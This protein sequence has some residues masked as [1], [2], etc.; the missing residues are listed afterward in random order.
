MLGQYIDPAPFRVIG[1]DPGTD[2]LGVSVLDANLSTN[3]ISLKSSQT[4][5]GSIMCKEYPWIIQTHGEKVARLKSH[6]D[7]LYNLFCQ[8]RP[9]EVVSEAPYMGRFPAAYAAL[10][11][12]L[13]AIRAALM[14][15]D[16]HMPL[17]TVDPATVKHTVGV[18]GKSGDKELMHKAITNLTTISNPGHI[19]LQMLD[20][21]SID[22]I[23]VA[24]VRAS[25]VTNRT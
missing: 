17:Y 9:H 10:V 3:E 11:E 12:C 22:S 15:Y 19:N 24:Y 7:N 8:Y 25:Y 14:R 2:T 23:A 21:H 20:E 4:F 16:A 13:N 6:E 1:I 5:K 18:S